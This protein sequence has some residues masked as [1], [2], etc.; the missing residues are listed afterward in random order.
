MTGV[1]LIESDPVLLCRLVGDFKTAGV[2][3]VAVASIA[4]LERWP[5]G[6]IIITDLAHLTPWWRSIGA[7]QVIVLVDRPQD[8]IEAMARGASGWLVRAEGAIAIAALG[9]PS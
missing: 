4:E 1:V 2:Q 6:Q 7:A 9:L 3:A 8:G 5:A